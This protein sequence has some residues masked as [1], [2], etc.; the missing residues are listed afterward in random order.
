MFR[1]IAP[2]EVP[3]ANYLEDIGI[4]F[5]SRRNML[6]YYRKYKGKRILLGD[7]HGNAFNGIY[8][9][10]RIHVS[11]SGNALDGI[12]VEQNGEISV[13]RY[14]QGAGSCRQ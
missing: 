14:Y 4:S 12:L 11:W 9:M 13:G 7:G 2:G 1:E 10:S 6:G 3:R 5:I 8:S